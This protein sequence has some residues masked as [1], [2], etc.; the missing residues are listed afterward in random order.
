VPVPER[1]KG[2]AGKGEQM[3]E[4][5]VM[6]ATINWREGQNQGEVGISETKRIHSGKPGWRIMVPNA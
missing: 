3:I 6:E 4:N 2:D 1:D 5:A